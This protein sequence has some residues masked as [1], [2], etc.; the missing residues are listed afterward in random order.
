MALVLLLV[1]MALGTGGWGYFRYGW[2]G[3]SPVGLVLVVLALLY[4]SGYLAA[5]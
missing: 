4:F 3:M 2:K 5:R 1:L